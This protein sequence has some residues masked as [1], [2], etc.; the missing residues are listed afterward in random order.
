MRVEDVLRKKNHR[1]VTVRTG[2]T[3]ETAAKLMRAEN[4]G[5]LVVK[6]VCRTE[7]NTV[8]GM[9]SERDIVHHLLTHGAKV[10]Q[11]PVSALMSRNLITCAPTDS[12]RHVLTLMRDHHIR[13]VPV[14]DGFTLVGLVGV[15]DFI[16]IRLAEM[17]EDDE[18]LAP[19]YAH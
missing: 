14:L 18:A 5:A 10:L 12:L 2:E 13:H 16:G 4:I 8:V 11:M 3:V 17:A 9:F 1:I 15:R 19:A 6:E 7:G